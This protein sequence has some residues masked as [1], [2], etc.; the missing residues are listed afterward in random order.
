MYVFS[1]YYLQVST[2]GDDFHNPSARP[3]IVSAMSGAESITPDIKL[4][5]FTS[6]SCQSGVTGRSFID[7]AILKQLQREL[8][9]QVIDSE[10]D[11]RRKY[12]LEEALKSRPSGRRPA[13]GKELRMIKKKLQVPK[14]N[15]DKW[16]TVP[17]IFTRKSSRFELPLDSRTLNSK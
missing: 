12:A 5:P 13:E 4:A 17:R 3:S 8:D 10:F 7:A 15:D 14:R 2:L 1:I 16:L 6:A 11:P 9:Q